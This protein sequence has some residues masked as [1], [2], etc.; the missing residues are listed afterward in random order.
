MLQWSTSSLRSGCY[1]PARAR[2]RYRCS[3]VRWL[4]AITAAVTSR[5]AACAA[6]SCGSDS[7]NSSWHMGRICS[8][9]THP[10]WHQ[11]L[12]HQYWVA[13]G[14]GGAGSRL[15]DHAEVNEGISTHP[16]QRCQ[17]RQQ[18][19]EEQPQSG[20]WP[21]RNVVCRPVGR[22]QLEPEGMHEAQ[23]GRIQQ[24]RQRSGHQRQ[25]HLQ[26][27]GCGAQGRAGRHRQRVQ[28]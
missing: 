20:R 28:R 5:A 21:R 10:Q 27:G 23:G 6:T 26:A 11:Q 1:V 13:K 19:V 12:R 8:S 18:H 4:A 9:R 7:R 17:Q 22:I 25:R 16:Q 2:S 3:R 24:H 15:T 14:A